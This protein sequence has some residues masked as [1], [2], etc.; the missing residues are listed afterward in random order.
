[1]QSW[2]GFRQ[3]LSD[4]LMSFARDWNQSSPTAYVTFSAIIRKIEPFL[5]GLFKWPYEI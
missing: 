2:T 5:Y 4:L 1:M 3:W